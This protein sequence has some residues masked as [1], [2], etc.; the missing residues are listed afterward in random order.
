MNGRA[1][2]TIGGV[3]CYRC[4]ACGEWKSAD[5][6]YRLSARQ[7]ASAPN[8]C[9]LHSECKVCANARRRRNARGEL[10]G[11]RVAPNHRAIGMEDDAPGRVRVRGPLPTVQVARLLGISVQAVS[12]CEKRA[13]RRLRDALTQDGGGGGI[14]V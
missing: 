1:V 2:N 8:G 6:F 3:P 13:M 11:R 9:G 4:T 5:S 14:Y 12:E 10:V 7:R